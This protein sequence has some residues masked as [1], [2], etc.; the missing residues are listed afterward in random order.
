V[1]DRLI[2]EDRNPR[3][4]YARALANYSL[5]RKAEAAADIEAAIRM[6][7]SNPNLVEWQRKIQALP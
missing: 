1:L 7:P 2:A 5:K 3:A 6:W 4:Y